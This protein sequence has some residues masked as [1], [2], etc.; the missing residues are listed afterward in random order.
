MPVWEGL[1]RKNEETG[2]YESYVKESYVGATLGEYE[3]NGRDDSDFYA[4]VWDEEKQ[5]VRS[6]EYNSTR[7]AGGGNCVVDA[8]PEVL[9]K[10]KAYYKPLVAENIRKASEIEAK[11]IHK[12]DRVR[13]VKGRKVKIGTEGTLFWVGDTR[14][15]TRGGTVSTR[16]GIKT[17]DGETFFLESTNLEVVERVWK[18]RLKSDEQVEKEAS[19]FV[20][21]P[22][23]F[24]I[25]EGN[26]YLAMSNSGVR[27]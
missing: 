6:F 26:F 27:F 15:F 17:D 4:I 19:R 21:N 16:V 7:Y 11:K 24:A 3:R 25:T 2:K 23:W 1:S 20:E 22:N 8:T 18:S 9:A 13:V 12:G 5:K 10:A 14:S